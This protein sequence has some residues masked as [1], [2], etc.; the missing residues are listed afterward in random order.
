[1]GYSQLRPDFEF[2]FVLVFF[3]ILFLCSCLLLG[4]EEMMFSIILVGTLYLL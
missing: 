1:M 3:L 4:V 2:N